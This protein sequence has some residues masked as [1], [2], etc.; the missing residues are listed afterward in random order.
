M[1]RDR[2]ESYAREFLLEDCDLSWSTLAQKVGQTGIRIEFPVFELDLASASYLS[3]VR[4]S[5]PEE[6]S[7]SQREFIDL[8]FRM[9]LMEAAAAESGGTLVI[10][11]PESSLDAVFVRRAAEVLARFGNAD[12]MNRLV[13]TSNLT[14]GDLVPRLLER[15]GFD[16]REQRIVDLFEIAEPTAAV[17]EHFDEYNAVRQRLWRHAEGGARE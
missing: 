13:V 17:R 7:E 16:S 10:D 4:R 1:V 11:A 9:A 3:P 15:C 6:V 12:E 5:G 2:F 8:S 14:D